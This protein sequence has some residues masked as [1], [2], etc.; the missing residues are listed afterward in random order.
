[1]ISEGDQAILFFISKKF[2]G[3]PY[4]SII[5]IKND[6]KTKEG[7]IRKHR[8]RLESVEEEGISFM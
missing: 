7:R 6:C 8:S 2:I 1:M 5:D 3:E 4:R